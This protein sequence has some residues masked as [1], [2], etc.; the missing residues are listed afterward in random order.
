MEPAMRSDGSADLNSGVR[1]QLTR[2]QMTAAKERELRR[3]TEPAPVSV[4]LK[5]ATMRPPRAGPTARARLLLAALRETESGIRERGTS[6]GTMACQAGLFMA[7]PILRRKVKARRVQG[8]T[9]PRKVR[10]ARMATLASIQAC[11][12]MRSL[13]RS[14]MSAV[15]P[16]RRPSRRTGRLAAVCMRA[17]SRGEAVRDVMSQVPAVSC[18]Q[19]PRLEMVL[20]IQRS[21]K[22]G[23]RKGANPLTSGGG[24]G[25]AVWGDS[26]GMSSSLIA[27][28]C[29]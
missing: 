13:R 5:V 7:A 6:S 23:M 11:Q 20:A 3:K 27:I 18:I 15:A 2:T 26:R 21:R 16:A 17:M 19:V 1:F 4:C 24:E 8:E 28:L 22:S 29:W 12:K 10:M 14:K 25:L 9:W